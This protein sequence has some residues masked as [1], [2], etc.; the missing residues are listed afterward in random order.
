MENIEKVK[1]N[2]LF[3]S[4]VYSQPKGDYFFG[5][6]MCVSLP[7]WLTLCF[8]CIPLLLLLLLL[9]TT[10]YGVLT[11]LP[12]FLYEQ[13]RR[14]ANAFF[15]FIALMQVGHAQYMWFTLE[16]ATSWSI[17][18]EMCW[19]YMILCGV[20]L[21]NK[22]AL[23]ITFLSVTC[24]DNLTVSNQTV[25]VSSTLSLRSSSQQIPDVSPTGRYTTL[26]PLIFIL[27]VAGIKEI[28]E[29]Y[30]SRTDTGQQS[31]VS[32]HGSAVTGQL[33]RCGTTP[34]R[35]YKS[36]PLFQNNCLAGTVPFLCI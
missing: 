22:S 1:S 24:T 30:V 13:I 4:T 31:R 10:K 35:V 14:A 21:W 20:E 33:L 2:S 32:N 9:S 27:T 19:Q 29:D 16:G 18:I 8:T 28:I 11:F 15:L 5:V 36:P 6:R 26:V 17:Q 7:W 3:L 34:C 12:R 23:C 25:S